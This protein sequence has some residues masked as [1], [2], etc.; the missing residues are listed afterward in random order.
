MRWVVILELLPGFGDVKRLIGKAWGAAGLA[1]LLFTAGAA[2]AQE[3]DRKAGDSDRVASDSEVGPDGAPAVVTHNSIVRNYLGLAECPLYGNRFWQLPN[4]DACF[5]PIVVGTVDVF[6]RTPQR[7][8]DVMARPQL[9]AGFDARYPTAFGTFRALATGRL[10]HQFTRSGQDNNALVDPTASDADTQQGRSGLDRAFF[11]YVGFTVGRTYSFFDYSSGYNLSDARVSQRLSTLAAY[12]AY[13]GDS[14]SVSGSVEDHYDRKAGIYGDPTAHVAS[15]GIP[16]FTGVIR[17]LAPRTRVQLSVASNVVATDNPLYEKRTGFGV[18][19]AGTLYFPEIG[20]P[21]ADRLTLSGA[22][23]E[24]A[25]SYIGFTSSV[26]DAVALGNNLF[27][28]RG[29]NVA[30]SYLHYWSPQWSSAFTVG[31]ASAWTDLAA[32]NFSSLDE[33]KTAANIVWRPAPEWQIGL[34]FQHTDQR[35]VFAATT[36]NRTE[37]GQFRIRYDF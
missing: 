2:Q 14:W 20:V 32:P 31:Y 11:E 22:F 34:E 6:E 10:V 29:W 1:V 16:N 12:T 30:A 28:T 25:A 24:G 7:P 35:T 33:W 5:R 26:P 27:L 17:H 23:S 13:F 9:L 18:Q 37:R 21:F 36:R 3:A 15:G 19:L 4:S 8:T